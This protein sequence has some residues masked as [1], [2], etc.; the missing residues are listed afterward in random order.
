MSL[1]FLAFVGGLFTIISPCILPGLLFV[2]ARFRQLFRTSI[3]QVDMA[4]LFGVLGSL[5]A[6]SGGWVVHANQT[7]RLAALLLLTFFGL[8]VLFPAIADRLSQ[9]VE[10]F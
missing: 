1:L 9:P 6:V 3:L 4:V 5:A 7:G 8:V 2:F 10:R